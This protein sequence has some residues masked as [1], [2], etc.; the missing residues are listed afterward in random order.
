MRTY[1]K[2]IATIQTG[3][4]NGSLRSSLGAVTVSA[5]VATEKVACRMR[6]AGAAPQAIP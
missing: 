4:G 5:G 1:D 2:L 6:H 3:Q